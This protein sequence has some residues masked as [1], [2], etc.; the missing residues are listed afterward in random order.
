MP[1]VFLLSLRAFD[2]RPKL[3]LKND[4]LRGPDQEEWIAADG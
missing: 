2:T 3:Q 1:F 4:I